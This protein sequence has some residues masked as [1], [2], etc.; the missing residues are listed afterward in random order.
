MAK[1]KMAIVMIQ[2]AIQSGKF[3]S[4]IGIINTDPQM[5]IV[6]SIPK[7]MPRA[8]LRMCTISSPF[9]GKFE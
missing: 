4:E 2:T 3:P 9:P 1:A 6:P 5:D 8:V 7:R